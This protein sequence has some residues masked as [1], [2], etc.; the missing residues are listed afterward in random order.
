MTLTLLIVS[1]QAKEYRAFFEAARLPELSFS[2]EPTSEVDILFGEP[3]R[4]RSAL[5]SVPALRWAQSNWA[6]V[7]PLLEPDVRRDYIL[8][9]AQGVFGKLMAEFVFTYILAYERKLI[10]RFQAQSSLKWDDR[11]T[12]SPRRKTLGLLGVG[13]IGMEIARTAKFFEMHVKGLTRKNENCPYVDEYYHGKPE[14]TGLATNT[15][16]LVSV[17]PATNITRRIIDKNVLAAL[18]THALFFN[19]G[20]GSAVD[21]SALIDALRQKKLAG[22]ILDVFDREPLPAGHPFWKTPNLTLTFHTAAP[23]LVED[24]GALFIENYQLFR[25]GQPVKYQVDFERGY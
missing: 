5:P 23:S 12:G 1:R 18:P 15:D 19:V 22:A 6:G 2:D 16:Y 8:T 21:E 7:E 4:I 20:R 13:S 9:N 25:A 3:D 11:R 24:I 14:I 10:E 17:L